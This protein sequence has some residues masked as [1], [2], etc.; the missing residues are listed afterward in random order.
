MIEIV[1]V[2]GS[3]AIEATSLLA[4]SIWREHFTPIIGEQQVEYMLAKFLSVSEIQN[5]IDSGYEFFQLIKE[6]P[7]GFLSIHPEEDKMFISKLY[8][9]QSHRGHGYARM[10]LSFVESYCQQLGI[11]T[12]WLTCNKHNGN[13]IEIYKKMGFVI[14]DDVIN[15]IGNRYVMDDYYLKKNYKRNC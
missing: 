9:Q 5:N 3:G 12:I 6:K 13:T 15:D 4:A 7:I 14:F 8:V 11:K 1:K 10:A 2:T